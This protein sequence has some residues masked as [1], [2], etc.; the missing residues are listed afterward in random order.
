MLVCRALPRDETNV[1]IEIHGPYS[2]DHHELK[3]LSH[4]AKAYRRRA[5]GR[6]TC[7]QKGLRTDFLCP[8]E[9]ETQ[10]AIDRA[11]LL[12]EMRLE[13]MLAPRCKLPAPG[14]RPW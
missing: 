7:D 11:I 9:W 4:L 1:F 12:V 6:S 13:C 5:D 8:D 3:K 10:A 2:G 14:E